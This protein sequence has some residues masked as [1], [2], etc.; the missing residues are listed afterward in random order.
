VFTITLP[1]AEAPPSPAPAMAKAQ[2]E[3]G[4]PRQARVLYVEDNPSNVE[5]LRQ[6]LSLRPGLALTVATDGPGGLAQA[7]GGGWDLLLIDIDLPGMDGMELCR[8]VRAEPSLAALP[9]IALS[10]NAM[11][12]ETRRA[13][14]AGFDAYLTKPLDV[15]RL[16]E[17]V[18]RRLATTAPGPR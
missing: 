1:A 16:L 8:R 17:E 14:Q 2:P 9:M 7:Q 11:P 18:D 10:A 6:V 13:L 4:A 15:V 3:T 12:A 5:L